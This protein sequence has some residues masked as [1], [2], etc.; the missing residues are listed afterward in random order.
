MQ[1]PILLAMKAAAA[2]LAVIVLVMLS[3]VIHRAQAEAALHCPAGSHVVW[4]S[5]HG[6]GRALCGASL[7]V[8][9]KA[10]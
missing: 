6:G 10:R 7:T 5:S 3:H 9:V 8:G 2:V 1:D 4:D